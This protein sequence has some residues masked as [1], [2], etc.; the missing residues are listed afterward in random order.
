M[1]KLIKTSIAL[2]A[3]AFI[4]F[5]FIHAK[6]TAP[7]VS[8]S[9]LGMEKDSIP[10]TKTKKTSTISFNDDKQRVEMNLENDQIVS[11]R[12]DGKEIPKEKYKE[13]KSLTDKIRKDIPV[14]PSP[15]NAP[16][17]PAPPSP[18][19]APEAPAPPSWGSSSRKQ[20]VIIED[21]DGKRSVLTQDDNAEI[22]IEGDDV[23]VNGKK[24]DKGNKTIR[25][26]NDDNTP[27]SS[28]SYSWSSSDS[29]SNESAESQ[30]DTNDFTETLGETLESDG[31][32]KN[33]DK[34]TFELSKGT[35]KINGTK[36]PIVIYQKYAKLYED[37]TGDAINGKTKVAINS[38]KG[39]VNVSISTTK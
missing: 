32:I 14:P 22:T 26:E 4:V 27:N 30:F 15:S 23:F 37:I 38:K 11:L 12:I 13:Y 34:Y 9:F 39:D 3:T 19:N 24:I 20:R 6:N 7:F 25:I 17:A 10:T 5:S 36:Q 29:D 28:Y 33:S 35:L 31:L 8:A 21:K 16:E 1:S 2:F 18:S